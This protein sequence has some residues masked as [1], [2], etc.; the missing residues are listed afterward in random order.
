[1][2][3]TGTLFFVPSSIIFTPDLPTVRQA[4]DS[5]LMT[6]FKNRVT[7]LF[8][9]EYPIIQAGMIWASGWRLASAVSN[10]GGLGIIGSGSMYPDVLKEHIQKCK[11]AT[12]RSFGV[13]VPLLY[14]DIDKHIQIIIDEGV[15]IVFTSAGNPKT[16]TGIL[17]EK[18]IT[19]VHVVSS[20][21]FAMKSEEAGCDA[22]V[23]EGFEA[24]G[25]NGRE[26]TTTMVLIPAVVSAVKIPVIAA[27]G[28]AN[29]RQMLAAMVLGAEGVQMGSRFVASEEASSHIN[30]KD[31]VIRSEEGDTKLTLK[32]LTP[33]RMMKNEFFKEIQQAELR[34]ATIEELAALLGRARA[35]KGMFEGDLE[36]GELEI[37]QVSSL[38]NNILPAS[39]IVKNV[40]KEFMSG[41][42]DP[43]KKL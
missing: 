20:S 21:K 19:V 16:W 24:G 11:S 41:L 29:G 22:V 7:E 10:A 3:V 28:I 43:L 32:Q 36:Q 26:E 35:K 33:V 5:R 39:E 12:S 34:G 40:W 13:N 6:P 23:A 8:G 42:A 18:G 37:G 1:L 31:K 2:L 17:K 9:I 14:P 4:N 27:G 25:H 30:F 15:K 38:L